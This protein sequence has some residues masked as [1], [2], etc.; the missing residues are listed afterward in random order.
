MEIRRRDIEIKNEGE[1]VGIYQPLLRYQAA[2][3][4]H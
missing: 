3:I 4:L 2:A 1:E